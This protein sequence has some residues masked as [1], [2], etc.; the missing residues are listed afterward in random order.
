MPNQISISIS[1]YH[2]SSCTQLL[3][4]TLCPIENFPTRK[5]DRARI[6]SPL[7]HLEDG[8]GDEV[9][10][11]GG[12]GVSRDGG[13]DG[14]KVR[15]GVRDT[16]GLGESERERA[17]FPTAFLTSNVNFEPSPVVVELSEGFEK[18]YL[19]ACGRCGVWFG[20]G[21]GWGDDLKD[22]NGVRRDVGY[23]VKGG[24]V[25]TGEVI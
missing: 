8:V 23:V 12:D 19:W 17:I 21:L 7:H 13:G 14:G 20:Y 2:C 15:D 22:R 6:L 4:A 25:E 24:L 5:C 11:V 10:G 3:L 18:R 9:E 16:K 1:T